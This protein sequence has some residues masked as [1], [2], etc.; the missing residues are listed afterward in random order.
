MDSVLHVSSPVCPRV[1]YNVLEF[2]CHDI[3]A[4]YID[5]ELENHPIA[6]VYHFKPSPKQQD[7][8]DKYKTDSNLSLI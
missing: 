6:S 2:F 3:I 8:I 4:P 1:W 7:W 5:V